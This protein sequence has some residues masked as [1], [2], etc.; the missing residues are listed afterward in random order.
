MKVL[1]LG[2]K[3]FI[4]RYV[5]KALT[6]RGIEVM[7]GTR[8]ARI[9][10]NGSPME[11]EIKLHQRTHSVDWQSEGVEFDV[12]VNCAGILRA[13]WR[14]TFDAVYRQAPIAIATACAANNTRLIHVTALGLHASASSGFIT[15]K[16]AGEIGIAA[17]NPS[18]CIVRPSLLDGVDGF[19]ARWLRRVAQWPVH[20][21]PSD[22]RGNLAPLDVSELGEAIAALCVCNASEL[23]TSVELGGETQFGMAEYLHALRRRAQPAISVTVP[24]WLV[25]CVAHVFDV[26]HFTPLSWGHQELMRRD[27]VPRAT[28][29]YAL[30]RWLGRAPLHVAPSHARSASVSETLP[31]VR[32]V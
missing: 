15:A 19:G 11:R 9:S 4:G 22:A 2:G 29:A 6:A 17:A 8:H 28:D 26:L 25:R 10:N 18:A 23:P 5:V 20:F 30:R 12:I 1:V 24:S 31:L 27:N 13:R 3:G 32:S 16:L 21:V 14:E 7:I